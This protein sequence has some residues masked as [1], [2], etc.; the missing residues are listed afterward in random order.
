MRVKRARSRAENVGN[1]LSFRHDGR[2]FRVDRE[3][4]PFRYYACYRRCEL[5]VARSIDE[6]VIDHRLVPVIR[7]EGIR[8]SR[9]HGLRYFAF[10]SESFVVKNLEEQLKTKIAPLSERPSFIQTKREREREREEEKKG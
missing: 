4:I 1:T 9:A 2:K 3:H 10:P 5:T 6:T 7:V 8:E